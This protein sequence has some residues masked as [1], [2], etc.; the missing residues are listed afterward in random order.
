M[1]GEMKLSFMAHNNFV[2]FC[3]GRFSISI[4]ICETFMCHVAVLATESVYYTLYSLEG[5]LT[6]CTV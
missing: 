4:Q 5:H 6:Q 2:L 1:F 3:S